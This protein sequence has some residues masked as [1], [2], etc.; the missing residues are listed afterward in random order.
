MEIF[1]PKEISKRE[2][3][4]EFDNDTRTYFEGYLI[5]IV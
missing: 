5:K 2:F 3:I 4:G 1:N